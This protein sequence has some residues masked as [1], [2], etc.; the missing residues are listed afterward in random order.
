MSNEKVEEILNHTLGNGNTIG[1]YGEFDIGYK[2][3]LFNSFD[4]VL[5]AYTFNTEEEAIQHMNRIIN[6]EA[7]TYTDHPSKCDRWEAIL[8]D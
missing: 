2:L 7:T 5:E 6:D 8:E 1:I 4:K 3:I